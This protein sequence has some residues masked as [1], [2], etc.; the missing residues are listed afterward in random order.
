MGTGPPAT[1]GVEEDAKN[2]ESSVGEA[3]VGEEDDE[4]D[5]L[6]KTHGSFFAHQSFS[7]NQGAT[8]HLWGPYQSY[9]SFGIG[10]RPP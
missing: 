6:G 4:R 10:G 9:Q 5:A 8:N 3:T 7:I 1:T 2:A